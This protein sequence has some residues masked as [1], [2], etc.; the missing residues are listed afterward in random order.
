MRGVKLRP[1]KKGRPE[2]Q[3]CSDRWSSNRSV[4]VAAVGLPEVERVG[5][6]VATNVRVLG[7][8]ADSGGAAFLQNRGA[9]VL[10]L[11]D[12]TLVKCSTSSLSR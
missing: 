3:P 2:G 12:V 4:I 11:L 7:S 8:G 1:T 6:A 9:L 5:R 10:L